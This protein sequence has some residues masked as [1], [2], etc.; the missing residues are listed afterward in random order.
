[1]PAIRRNGAYI[2]DEKLEKLMKDA[3]MADKLLQALTEETIHNIAL[4]SKNAEL[5]Y[6]GEYY[7]KVLKCNKTLM[8]VTVIA[9]DY[10]MTAADLNKLLKS[11]KVQFKT[12][13]GTWVLYSKYHDM[14]YTK[15]KTFLV[16]NGDDNR[17]VTVMY[18]TEKGKEL[19]Y[20]ILKKRG[21]LPLSEYEDK[22]EAV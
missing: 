7:D 19:I 16:P 15:T 3:A 22:F 20:R 18:W 8:S 12:G 13:S 10:G 2:T 1:M 4:E 9:K 5:E 14:G 6:K 17:T 21:I 11:F